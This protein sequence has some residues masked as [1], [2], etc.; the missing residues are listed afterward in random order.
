MVSEQSSMLQ[1]VLLAILVMMSR[2]HLSEL[3]K[4]QDNGLDLIL[5]VN[6]RNIE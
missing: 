6:V 5:L 3:V 1:L 4:K 2:E